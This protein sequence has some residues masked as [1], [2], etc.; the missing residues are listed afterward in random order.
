MATNGVVLAKKAP[1]HRVSLATVPS[2]LWWLN[3]SLCVQWPSQRN[4]EQA[5]FTWD[6][7]QYDFT[8]ESVFHDNLQ[9]IDNKIYVYNLSDN[10]IRQIQPGMVI[11]AFGGY[12]LSSYQDCGVLL[13]GYITDVQTHW[14][15]SE[16]CTEIS[17]TNLWQISP[18][19][20]VQQTYSAPV[21]AS[22]V[23][24]QLCEKSG[25]PIGEFSLR[26]DYA[27]TQSLTLEGELSDVI[28]EMAALCGV[29]AY[30][31][32]GALY[33]RDL[34]RDPRRNCFVLSEA[35]GLIQTPEL[36]VEN[37]Y[38]R[39]LPQGEEAEVL[40]GYRVQSLLN[41]RLLPG[42][43]VQLNARAAQGYFAV[44]ECRHVYEGSGGYTE[45]VLLA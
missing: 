35:S 42:A 45:A 20:R 17:A 32:Q 21:M 25:L 40:Q 33:V 27:F 11:V 36:L 13:N 4:T 2:G 7:S 39:Y 19:I 44:K 14:D 31:V 30:V 23:L 29:W 15:K 43:G 37:R 10:T 38:S 34:R 41:H 22:F 8:F 18:G 24:Q 28:D 16:K 9:A 1:F 3:M 5:I 12:G 6:Q 26:S